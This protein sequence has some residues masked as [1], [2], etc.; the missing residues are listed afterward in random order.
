MR[1]IYI[2][3]AFLCL[4]AFS[5]YSQTNKVE[6]GNYV[7]SKAV[8]AAYNYNTK[9]EVF[10]YTFNDTVSLKKLD[11]LPFPIQPV[12]LS[13][14]MQKGVLAFCKLWNDNMDYNVEDEGR[15][16]VPAKLSDSENLFSQ[17]YRL[18]PI[19]KLDIDGNTATFTFTEPYGSGLYSF[20]LEGKFVIVLVREESKQ[21]KSR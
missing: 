13:A 4:Y 16:L 12:F 18:S 2:V 19:Y 20:P 7:F 14:Y 1:L 17:P 5:V 10:T 3:T 6:D 21:N 11:E 9:T 8:V 15:I